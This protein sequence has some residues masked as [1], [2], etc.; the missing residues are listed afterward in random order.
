MR[1]VGGHPE[2][3]RI[4]ALEP[5]AD[6]DRERPGDVDVVRRDGNLL[7]GHNG[8]DYGVSTNMYLVPDRGVGA[9][10][11]TNRYIGGWDAWYAFLDIQDRLLS[12]V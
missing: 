10:T 3:Y 12:I 11:L 2:G 7:I 9:I 4:V 6:D 1:A 5:A 8:G